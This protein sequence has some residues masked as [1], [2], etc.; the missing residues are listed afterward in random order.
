MLIKLATL[1]APIGLW[2]YY[3]DAIWNYAVYAL[4]KQAKVIIKSELEKETLVDLCSGNLNSVIF[5]YVLENPLVIRKTA[6]LFKILFETERFKNLSYSLSELALQQ[7][8][9]REVIQG[10]LLRKS[11]VVTRDEYLRRETSSVL[12]E[13]ISKAA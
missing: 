6:D 8:P 2:Y 4:A 5:T 10:S 7:Q 12:H 1:S 3:K 13:E 9:V 11:M